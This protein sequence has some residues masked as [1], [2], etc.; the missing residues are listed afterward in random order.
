MSLALIRS[1]PAAELNPEQMLAVEHGI[2]EAAGPGPLL[3]IA[4][5]GSGKT[6]MLAH[7]VA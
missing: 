1:A 7:R 3:V 5:A 6:A 4:G 2:G